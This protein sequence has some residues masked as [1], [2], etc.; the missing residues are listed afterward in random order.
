[1]AP[2]VTRILSDLHYGDPASRVRSLDALRPL[3]GGADRVVFNGDSV[4]TR[5]SPIAQQTNRIREEFLD[6][7]QS[8]VRSCT[9]ITGNHDPDLSAIH[10]LELL[11]GLVFITHGEVLF[12]DLV[13]WSRELPEI[14]EFFRQELAA[15]PAD[16]REIPSERL[17][18]A[19]RACVRLELKHDPHPVD[20]WGRIHRTVHTFWPPRRVLAMLKAWRQLPSRAATFARECRPGVRFVLVGHTHRPGVWTRSDLVI[21]N[22]GSFRPPFGCYAVDVSAPQIVVR[23]VVHAGGGFTLGRVVAAF[24]LAPTGGGSTDPSGLLP[25]LAPAP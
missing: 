9:V 1:V 17:A 13:P 25:E 18:A 19:K 5:R 3:F 6:F 20:P 14:R 16:R 22:T 21:I 10:H 7:A 2:E 11:G 12:D 15:V 23:Q 24:A 4:E 8:A